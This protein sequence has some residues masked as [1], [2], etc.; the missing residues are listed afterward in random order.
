MALV[1][2]DVETTGLD[3]KNCRI[4]QIALYIPK[5]DQG[6][7]LKLKAEDG[8]LQAGAFKVNGIDPDTLNDDDRMSQADGIRELIRW[9][10]KHSGGTRLNVCCH[11]ADFDQAWVK[12]WFTREK[13]SFKD[14]F[15][16]SWECTYKMYTS[17]RNWGL[18]RPRGVKLT[19]LCNY[20]NIRVKGA[21]DA[22]AD[23]K[24]TVEIYKRLYNF[25]HSADINVLRTGKTQ[26]PTEVEA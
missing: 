22:L 21:H 15:H 3:S 14:T 24:M 17:L 5:I 10:H 4:I 2:L 13:M 7:D 8:E 12:E 19:D 26:Q 6:L 23:V 25:I 20:L 18:I 11:N 1:F 16:W 9:C